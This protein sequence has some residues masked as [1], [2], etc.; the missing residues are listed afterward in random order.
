MMA[1]AI[2][3]A[4]YL[5]KSRLRAETAGVGITVAT[6]ITAVVDIACPAAMGPTSM[7]GTVNAIPMARCRAD[8]GRAGYISVVPTTTERAYWGRVGD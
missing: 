3:T 6:D 8:V 1:C 4:T 5:L 2:Q 7:S